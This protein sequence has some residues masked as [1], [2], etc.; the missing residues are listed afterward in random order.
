M[1][2]TCSKHGGDGKYRVL[3]RKPEA[4]KPIDNL[5]VDRRI[6]KYTLNKLAEKSGTQFTWFRIG[7]S[8]MFLYKR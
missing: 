5:E 2:N 1:D 8:D 4:R 7:T 6:L 3:I